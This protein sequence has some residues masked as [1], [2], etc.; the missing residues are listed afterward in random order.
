MCHNVV[1]I[2]SCAPPCD[3]TTIVTTRNNRSGCQKHTRSTLETRRFQG[4]GKLRLSPNT[5]KHKTTATSQLRH[6]VTPVSGRTCTV[7]HR[8]VE[9]YIVHITR[10]RNIV[11]RQTCGLS[12]P[13]Q[14]TFSRHDGILRYSHNITRQSV[15]MIALNIMMIHRSRHRQ[16]VIHSLNLALQYNSSTSTAVLL[17]VTIILEVCEA[18]RQEVSVLLYHTPEYELLAHIVAHRQTWNSHQG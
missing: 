14:A 8:R 4:K 6:H 15:G 10:R 18:P 13:R 9:L 5:M 17:W 3:R 2:G 1:N 7:V 11:E 16:D 12:A